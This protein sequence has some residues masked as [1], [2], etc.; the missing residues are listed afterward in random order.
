MS[1]LITIQKQGES[2]S[3]E[4]EKK[5]I[6]FKYFSDTSVKSSNSIDTYVLPLK[7]DKL[8]KFEFA[9]RKF[10]YSKALDCVMIQHIAFKMPEVVVTLFDELIRYK[11]FFFFFRNE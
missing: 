10:Q 9:L 8:A 11:C 7:K 2:V 3:E 1:G 5:K 6:P 4:P